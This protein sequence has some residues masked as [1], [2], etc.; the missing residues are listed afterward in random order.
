MKFFRHSRFALIA[1]LL[2]LA[3]LFSSCNLLPGFV[4]TTTP[5]GS[6][7]GT[8]PAPNDQTTPP[9]NNQTL[10]SGEP[11]AGP[12]GIE[13]PGIRASSTLR[14]T[15]TRP[16]LTRTITQQTPMRPILLSILLAVAA[17][18][19]RALARI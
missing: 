19:W 3:T 4:E 1:L 14:S 10:P 16:I 7:F 11:F 17:W 13:S 5:T 6:G 8:T 2:V 12:F 18:Q 15:T 9:E